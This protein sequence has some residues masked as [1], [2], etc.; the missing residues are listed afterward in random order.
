MQWRWW[1]EC[2]YIDKSGNNSYYSVC[3]RQNSHKIICLLDA[4]KSSHFEVRESKHSFLERHLTSVFEC[5][6]VKIKTK[7]KGLFT[8]FFH[9]CSLS[10][11]RL[12]STGKTK[13]YNLPGKLNYVLGNCRLAKAIFSK[14]QLPAPSFIYIT[15]LPQSSDFYLTRYRFSSFHFLV[16]CPKQGPWLPSLPNCPSGDVSIQSTG[17]CTPVCS[18]YG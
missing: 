15:F 1:P 8:V 13:H 14:K 2:G 11:N 18:L 16:A 4:H 12:C 3:Q 10:V 6:S 7:F 9:E 17:H 5:T